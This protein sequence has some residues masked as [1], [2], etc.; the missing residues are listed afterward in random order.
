[1]ARIDYDKVKQINKSVA[2]NKNKDF[3]LIIVVINKGFSDY[4]VDAARDAGASGATII[5]GRGTGV[6]ENDSILGIKIQ[7]EKEIVMILVYRTKRKQIMKQICERANLNEVG[8]GVCFSMPVSDIA[9][10]NHLILGSKNK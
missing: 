5:A 3:D 7:P 10:I 2:K 6:H 1:M 4:V 8:K 9:G